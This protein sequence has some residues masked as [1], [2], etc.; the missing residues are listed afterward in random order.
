MSTEINQ[1]VAGS[2][3]F[4]FSKVDYAEKTSIFKGQDAGL[5]D[6]LHKKHPTLQKLFVHLRS[7]DWKE[8]E[9]EFLPCNAEFK[10]YP[11][12]LS[13]MMKDTLA[14]QWEA[15][16][17]AAKM[18]FAV[19]APFIT[20]STAARLLGRILDN[21]HLHAATYSE[22]VNFS[23][24]DPTEVMQ[25]VVDNME[26]MRRLTTITNVMEESYVVSHKVALGMIDRN[27]DE[28]YDAAMMFM[29]AML[30]MERIAFMSSFVITFAFGKAGMFVPIATAVQKICQD[31]HEVHVQF[32]KYVIKHELSL[33]CGQAFMQRCGHKV[34]A[35]LDEAVESEM[36]WI[37]YTGIDEDP[38]VG[39][40][41]DNLRSQVRYFAGDAYATFGLKPDF[42]VPRKMPMPW[43][44]K[45]LNMGKT[46]KALQEEKNGQY[47]VNML[48]FVM[49][50]DE[51]IAVDF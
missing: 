15:D 28:A 9:F 34:Q 32:D 14:W 13:N 11:R 42:V 22:I 37:A 31:E 8:T 27:S 1:S 50:E 5:F 41:G 19:L 24:D 49:P 16:S 26:A 47:K 36:S 18:A 4:N 33:P 45:W 51:I 21:E 30:A 25:S 29:A 43:L 40:N 3:I 12:R 20:D 46:Q 35:L 7:I 44:I 2:K 38:I 17:V 48:R 6:T 39:V 10:R 23:F